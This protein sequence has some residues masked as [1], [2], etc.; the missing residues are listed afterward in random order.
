MPPNDETIPALP[1]TPADMHLI[2]YRLG[3]IEAAVLDLITSL[4]VEKVAQELTML[5]QSDRINE[6]EKAI[7]R[8]NERMTLWQFTQLG[9]ASLAAGVSGLAAWLLKR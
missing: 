9:F 7:I 2:A 5:G 3:R 8:I 1:V 4:K 6:V